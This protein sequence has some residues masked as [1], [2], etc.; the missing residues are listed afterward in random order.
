MD[1]EIQTVNNDNAMGDPPVGTVA[2]V[3]EQD[4]GQQQ[5]GDDQQQ[6]QG[7]QQVDDKAGKEPAITVEAVRELLRSERGQG[8]QQ[9]QEK[10][11][12]A[13]ELDQMFD[14]WKP[15][16]ELVTAIRE[17]DEAAALKAMTDMRNGLLKQA[18]KMTEYQMQI[19]K[20]ELLGQVQPAV[21]FANDQAAAKDR[22]E[23]FKA[24][25]D[26]RP[27]EKLVTTVFNALRAEGVKAPTVAAAYKLLADRTRALLP[28]NNGNGSGDGQSSAASNTNGNRPKPAQLSR[29]SQAGGGGGQSATPNVFADIFS[30]GP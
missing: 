18:N 5:G 6:Q 2:E 20:R 14:V 11:Y 4:D 15:Q 13:E 30:D 29:G 16:M 10:Q 23:F 21:A 12:T 25:E 3:Y 22:E 19:L 28:N 1:P 9:Q 17:G 27:N 26:L 7:Q 24:N 8:Q